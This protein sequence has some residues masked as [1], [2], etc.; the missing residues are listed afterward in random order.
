MNPILEKPDL[1]VI[2]KTTVKAIENHL[3]RKNYDIIPEP[4]RL[5]RR[6][7]WL[8]SQVKEFFDAKLTAQQAQTPLTPQ[9]KKKRGRPRKTA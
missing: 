9:Q 7:V 6:P 8:E 1:A 2:L 5:G 4:I 3:S